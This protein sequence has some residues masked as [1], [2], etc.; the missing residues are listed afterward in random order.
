MLRVR[1]DDNKAVD[2]WLE[3]DGEGGIN[4]ME[5]EEGFFV[6]HISPTG[7]LTL[8]DHMDGLTWV[9]E[10]RTNKTGT[11]LKVVYE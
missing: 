5:S 10:T 9:K 2:I 7:L 1:R 11:Y 3:E 8:F 4:I 6:A